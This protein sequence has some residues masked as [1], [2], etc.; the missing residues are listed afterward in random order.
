MKTIDSQCFTTVLCTINYA[1]CCSEYSFLNRVSEKIYN[2]C[3][4]FNFYGIFI[5][6]ELA[7]IRKLA[8]LPSLRSYFMSKATAYACK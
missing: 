1:H 7:F 2:A 4:S 6:Y 3:F 8:R 5:A